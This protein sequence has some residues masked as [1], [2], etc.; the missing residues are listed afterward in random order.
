MKMYFILEYSHTEITLLVSAL[1][2]TAFRPLQPFRSIT[3]IKN[4][5]SILTYSS[6]SVTYYYELCFSVGNIVA[7]YRHCRIIKVDIYWVHH[8]HNHFIF[9]S[10]LIFSSL[11][12]TNYCYI[13]IQS[14]PDTISP[15]PSLKILAFVSLLFSL[16]SSHLHNSW[17]YQ[18]PCRWFFQWWFYDYLLQWCYLSFSFCVHT[19]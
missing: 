9:I 6:S 19:I 1:K 8:R 13:S 16:T 12:G 11:K 15:L 14:S 2:P 17:L 5:S 7:S 18:Y 4:Q 3:W 10:S